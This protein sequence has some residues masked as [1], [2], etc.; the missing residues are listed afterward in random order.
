MNKIKVII[1]QEYNTPY[2]NELFNELN[3]FEDIELHLLY[4][5]S[6]PPS[7]KWNEKIKSNFHEHFIANDFINLS[8]E[9]N[10]NKI[11]Y[12]DLIKVFLRIK[13]DVVVTQLGLVSSLFYLISFYRKIRFVYWNEATKITDPGRKINWKYKIFKNKFTS[14]V[15]TGELSNEFLNFAGYKLSNSNTFIMPNSV[16]DIY[17]ISVSE[18]KEKFHKIAKLKILFV[19]S[20]IKRKGFDLLQDAIININKQGFDSKVEYH[21]I[22]AG[23]IELSQIPNVIIHGFLNSSDSLIL[24]KKSHAI[25][26]PSLWDCNPLVVVEALKCGNIVLLSDGVGSYPEFVNDNGF[27]FSR[28]SIE[29]IENV[30]LKLIA[31]EL[32]DLIKMGACS[33]KISENISHKNS[34]K[35]FYNAIQ[36][37]YKI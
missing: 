31:L 3:Y 11:K 24:Y 33:L 2:R 19:G 9:Q 1:I 22:G 35:S 12:L 14:F 18:F 17:S 30:I 7:R 20:F 6:L 36:Y 37:S 5:G 10:K 28:N 27:V 21:F 15:S 25:I 13:P 4:I 34:A 8:Y 26:V 23:D 29:D 16:D 32:S